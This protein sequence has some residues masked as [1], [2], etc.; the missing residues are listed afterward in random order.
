MQLMERV[1]IQ[2]LFTFGDEPQ[3]LEMTPVTVLVGANNSGKTNFLR[4]LRLFQHGPIWPNPLPMT[5]HR[6]RTGALPSPPVGQAEAVVRNAEKGTFPFL[7][8]LKVNDDRHVSEVLTALDLQNAPSVSREA[9]PSPACAIH[10]PQWQPTAE[11][12]CLQYSRITW[13]GMDEGKSPDGIAVL[14]AAAKLGRAERE[15]LVDVLQS[16]EERLGSIDYRR[17]GSLPR[18]LDRTGALMDIDLWSAHSRRFAV[19]AALLVASYQHS[20]I[21]LEE[22]DAGLHPDVVPTLHDL[23]IQA[24]ERAQVVMTT[25][26]YATVDT[27]TETPH[28]V[29]AVDRT[30]E[31]TILNRLD[32]EATARYMASSEAQSLTELW[33]AGHLGGTRY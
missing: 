22:P 9:V 26:R 3:R 7:H 16:V 30:P 2:N 13:R 24:S 28:F 29:V 10:N 23:V 15:Q 12:A 18:F 4:C 11:S 19:T 25:N 33:A 8:M 20:M 6:D 1:G 17:D 5:V 14:H 32:P 21:L 31:G 27:F